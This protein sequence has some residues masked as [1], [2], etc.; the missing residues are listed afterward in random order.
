MELPLVHEYLDQLLLRKG[1]HIYTVADYRCA[2]MGFAAFAAAARGCGSFYAVKEND[3]LCW[4]DTLVQGDGITPK[5]AHRKL[6][7]VY[8]FYQ[9]LKESGRLLVN[10]IL[11]PGGSFGRKLPR[12]LP[13]DYTLRRMY[14][15][16]PQSKYLA[17]QRDYAV[18][19]LA[20]GC[21][22]RRCE[23]QR[24]DVADIR[25]EERTI[26]VKGK[27]GRLRIVPIGE[28]TLK[29][30]QYY[31]YYIRP[32]ILK[33]SGTTKALFVTWHKGGSRIKAQTISTVFHRLRRKY[34]LERAFC[35]HGLRHAFATDLVR[36]GAAVQDVSAMLGHKKLTSTQVY[37][38]LV[39]KELKKH[40]HR[41]H[42][43]G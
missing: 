25:Q 26:S 37:T 34:G 30:L 6:W 24:L 38:H 33:G 43:R 4:F 2:L 31:L 22:L 20:Y 32:K 35:A 7:V 19:E 1:L 12:T 14:T 16:L 36:S 15:V 29:E 3:A 9:W 10:P 5:T 13:A 42:P 28:Q 23:L 27:G 11:K 18:I 21:G 41:F 40:H 17:E 8:R 39:P